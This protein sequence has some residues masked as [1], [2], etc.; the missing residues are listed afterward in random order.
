MPPSSRLHQLLGAALATVLIALAQVLGGRGSRRARRWVSRPRGRATRG[1][2]RRPEPAARAR[3]GARG[4]GRARPS[5]RAEPAGTA[6]APQV[7]AQPPAPPREPLEMLGEKVLPGTSVRLAWS[8][9]ESFEGIAVPTAVLVVNGPREGPTLCLTAALH[10][11]ELNGIEIVRRVMYELEPQKLSGTVIGVPIVN[12]HGFRRNSRYLPDRRDLNRFFPGANNGSSASRIAL[13][14]LQRGGPQVQR[15]GRHP[16]RIV[17]AHEPSPAARRHEGA[18]GGRPHVGLRRHVGAAQRGRG[19][20]AAPRRGG[21]GHSRRGAR[22]GRA[23]PAP[24]EQDRARHAGHRG[25][26][27]PPRHVRAHARARRA[28]ARLLRVDLGARRPRRAAVRRG[29]PGAAR[30]DGRAA[31]HRDRPDHERPLRAARARGRPRAR[32]W[33]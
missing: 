10:G 19:G 5:P 18:R 13:L 33:R 16:H 3:S 20:H 9:D 1:R 21:G 15:G 23:G 11:D 2:E 28:C 25:P 24:G 14:V 8:P 29:E 12:L 6:A 26:A 32:A 27:R 30:E 7:A 4:R 31:R 17:P 22:D